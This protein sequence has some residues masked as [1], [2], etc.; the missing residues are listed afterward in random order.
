MVNS[1]KSESTNILVSGMPVWE[2]IVRN[3][4]LEAQTKAGHPFMEIQEHSVSQMPQLK[5]RA[6]SMIMTIL[7][8]ISTLSEDVVAR[9]LSLLT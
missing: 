6:D 1:V 4:F 7:I 2:V 9:W 5:Q 8:Q 3:F